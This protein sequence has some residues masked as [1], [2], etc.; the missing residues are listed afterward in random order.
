[1]AFAGNFIQVLVNGYELTGDSNHVTIDDKRD[2]YDVTAFG[3]LAHNFLPGVRTF[4]LDYAGYLNANAA[5][6][7]SIIRGAAVKGIVSLL[8]GGN[9]PPAAGNPVYSLLAQ[10]G[11]YYD[12]P[13]N[14]EVRPVQR[15]VRDVQRPRWLERGAGRPN[16][17]HQ[18]RVRGETGWLIHQTA[19]NWFRRF[20][21]WRCK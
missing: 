12:A 3:D 14:C 11:K 19:A 10:Q 6:S 15:G 20:Q 1:M 4:A 21:A 13:G 17:H 2:T 5:G 18:L 9:A 7:H 8:V 16:E